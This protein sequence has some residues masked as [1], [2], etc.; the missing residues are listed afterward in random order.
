MALAILGALW[1][2]F[3]AVIF[4]T[5]WIMVHGWRRADPMA[6]VFMLGFVGS[7]L[8]HT[9]LGGTGG[10][11]VACT[12]L[13]L[14]FLAA[15]MVLLPAGKTPAPV[16]RRTTGFALALIMV[17]LCGYLGLDFFRSGVREEIRRQ[18]QDP[19]TALKLGDSPRLDRS[20]YIRADTI[21]FYTRHDGAPVG[22]VRTFS[23]IKAPAG[24]ANESFVQP[25]EVTWKN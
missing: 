21:P 14:W 1:I 18:M 17:V 3:G 12:Y 7:F 16:P 2:Q 5:T 23:A 10:L 22:T 25:C 8:V 15:A 6:L 9:L 13:F 20:L 4:L 24:F 19:K 11:R